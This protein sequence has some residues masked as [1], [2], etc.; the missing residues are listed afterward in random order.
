MDLLHQIFEGDHVLSEISGSKPAINRWRV[1]FLKHRSKINKEGWG[2]ITMSRL[3]F[4][5]KIN[6]YHPVLLVFLERS[7]Y[8]LCW[9]N[10]PYFSHAHRI[11]GTITPSNEGVWLFSNDFRKCI[12]GTS[13]GKYI[14]GTVSQPVK[15]CIAGRQ[16][17]MDPCL[18]AV[19]LMDIS[20]RP[21][22]KDSKN[23]SPVSGW[24]NS[25]VAAKRC[26][27]HRI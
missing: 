20:D 7:E 16:S 14:F 22:S 2:G 24:R 25:K 10:K 4:S 3:Y 9:A 17:A 13:S 26:L 15:A 23:M 6:K 11:L 12:Q 8:K 19:F 1:D 18:S 5:P 27:C 21:S